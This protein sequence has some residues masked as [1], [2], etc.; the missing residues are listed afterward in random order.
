MTNKQM[1]AEAMLSEVI[2]VLSDYMHDGWS[3]YRE[4][5]SISN[6]EEDGC[7]SSDWEAEAFYTCQRLIDL[8]GLEPPE[9]EEESEEVKV[10]YEEEDD[11]E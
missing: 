2:G 9:S 11:N 8:L 5:L 6:G 10:E 4:L 1:T 7:F 3:G